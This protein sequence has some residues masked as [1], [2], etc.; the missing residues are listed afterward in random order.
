MK[1]RT[2]TIESFAKPIAPTEEVTYFT[3][4]GKDSKDN[5]VVKEGNYTQVKENEFTYARCCGLRREL[6]VDDNGQL[7]NPIN[8]MFQQKNK[9]GRFKKVTAE[10]F[11]LYVDFLTTKQEKKFLQANR[12]AKDNT[13]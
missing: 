4:K 13:V 8:A 5:V 9:L 3:M 11:D 1:E 10:A 2:G 12:I 6:R 7:I